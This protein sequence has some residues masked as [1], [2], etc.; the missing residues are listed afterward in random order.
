MP[1][2]SICFGQARKECHEIEDLGTDRISL[3]SEMQLDISMPAIPIHHVQGTSPTSSSLRKCTSTSAQKAEGGLVPLSALEDTP[4]FMDQKTTATIVSPTNTLP[5]TEINEIKGKIPFI[6]EN[7]EQ[8]A[9]HIN[10]QKRYHN[11]R[12]PRKKGKKS[13]EL[14]DELANF[15]EAEDAELANKED[16]AKIQEMQEQEE[17]KKALLEARRMAEI[18]AID[19]EARNNAHTRD[20]PRNSILH[21][22]K[23]VY[24]DGSFYIGDLIYPS[25]KRE[26]KGTLT[27]KDNS[28]YYEG[29]W[30]QD[31]CHGHGTMK[32]K[33][34][35]VYEGSFFN[36]LPHGHGLLKYADGKTMYLGDFREGKKDGVGLHHYANGDRYSGGFVLGKRHG[37]GEAQY[38]SGALYR[39]LWHKDKRHDKCGY[40][41]FSNGDQ[42]TGE[43][44]HGTMHGNGEMAFKNGNKYSGSFCNNQAHGRGSMQW[45]DGNIFE[46]KYRNGIPTRGKLTMGSKYERR[47]YWGNF[48]IDKYYQEKIEVFIYDTSLHS[49]GLEG[50]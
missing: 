27:Y 18:K 32:Y 47:Q 20:L 3:S 25:M 37:K 13:T 9:P 43:F 40:Y 16:K 42:Y 5:I 6:I 35:S 46:G 21:D 19:D 17:E 22:Q 41:N 11:I 49:V 4:R 12:K 48:V 8:K 10:S 38:A 34:G 36:G 23:K 26:G 30:Q 24:S 39:G 28:G 33:D 1:G 29:E 14:L 44:Y 31:V 15:Y 45:T 2:E 50:K 7:V